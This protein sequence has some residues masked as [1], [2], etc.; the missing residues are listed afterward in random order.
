VKQAVKEHG[1]ANWTVIARMLRGRQPKQ[2]RQRYFN[3]VDPALS[4]KVR[5]LSTSTTS[6]PTVCGKD[7][8][9]DRVKSSVDCSQSPPLLQSWTDEEDKRIVAAQNRLGN[10]FAEISRYL[11]GRSESLVSHRFASHQS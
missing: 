6:A 1:N 11:D 9:I 4:T 5:T 8:A 10:R 3:K 7:S 2:C